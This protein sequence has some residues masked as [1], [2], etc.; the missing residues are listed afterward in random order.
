MDVTRVLEKE[1]RFSPTKVLLSSNSMCFSLS[2]S[3]GDVQ[4]KNVFFALE[5]SHT[6]AVTLP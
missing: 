1:K 2:K 4:K 5:R 6:L 3:T